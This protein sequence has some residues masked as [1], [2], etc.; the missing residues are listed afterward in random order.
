[1]ELDLGARRAEEMLVGVAPW[2]VAIRLERVGRG[3]AD[4][5]HL[6]GAF[7]IPQAPL[8]H[9][10]VVTGSSD[11]RFYRTVACV[12]ERQSTRTTEGA[13][14]AVPSGRSIATWARYG[15]GAGVTSIS[16][17]QSFFVSPLTFTVVPVFGTFTLVHDA[18]CLPR[19]SPGS[20]AV[21]QSCMSSKTDTPG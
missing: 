13:A 18:W 3:E 12:L 9:R 14:L 17:D 10:V 11:V 7:G 1:M 8:H 20:D 6:D 2:I 16:T 15:A 21:H 5:V 19:T 4:H